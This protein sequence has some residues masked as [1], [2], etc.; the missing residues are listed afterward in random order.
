MTKAVNTAKV[1]MKATNGV[2]GILKI[3][4]GLVMTMIDKKMFSDKFSWIKPDKILSVYVSKK[5][6][7]IIIGLGFWIFGFALTAQAETPVSPKAK[8]I[9]QAYLKIVQQ[10]KPDFPGFEAKLGEKFY[11]AERE[12]SKKEDTRSCAL[13]HGDDPA[14]IGQH[15]TSGKTI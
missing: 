5:L 13:C 9:L 3:T 2:R 14:S 6:W 7:L 15:V 4:A 10:E 12:H 8:Q 11:F 1:V